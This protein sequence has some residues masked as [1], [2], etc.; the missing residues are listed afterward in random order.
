[1]AQNITTY[2]QINLWGKQTDKDANIGLEAQRADLFV[3]DFSNA[4]KNVAVVSKQ[5]LTPLLPQYVRSCTLPEHKTKSEPIR[6]DSI[7]QNMPS[8][9]EPLEP[10]KMVFLVETHDQTDVSHTVDFLDA[11]LAVTR[12]GRGTR[13]SGYYGLPYGWLTLNSNYTIDFRFDINL[14]L[15]RGATAPKGLSLTQAGATDTDAKLAATQEAA[16]LAAAGAAPGAV[17]NAQSNSGVPNSANNMNASTGYTPDPNGAA[18]T[19]NMVIHTTY[20]LKNAWLAAYKLSDFSYKESDLMSVD[21]TFYVDA[22]VR[23]NLNGLRTRGLPPD[24]LYP[25]R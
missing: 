18:F 4:L 20:T 3:V 19:Q 8:W 12:A 5:N 15:L 1:M 13:S 22:V 17:T 25:D 11:W 23:K 14:Y 2:K 9:D 16:I 24:L 6:R 10:V 7:L 21:A